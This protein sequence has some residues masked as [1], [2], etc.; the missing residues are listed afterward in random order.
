M[1]T[2]PRLVVA[3]AASGQG[4]TTVSVGLMGALRAYGHAVAPAKCGP[5]Y[6]DP[7]YHELA[8]GRPSRNLDPW[9]TSPEL[10][11]PLF[12]RG[13]L[14]PTP[15]DVAVIEGVMGLFDGR[16]G[17]D[18]FASTAHVAALTDSPVLLVV[19]ISSAARTVGALVRG[20]ATHD[21]AVRVAG[22]VLNKAGSDRHAAEVR[23]AV[24]QQ[25][26]PVLGV[27]PRDAGI[28]A[29]SRH[30]GLVPAS[31]RHDAQ[32]SLD[33]L[34]EQ[35]AQ[36]IDIDAVFEIA[37][38]APQLD[39]EPWAPPVVD[40][41]ARRVAVAGGRAFTFHYAETAEMLAAAGCE[42]VRFDPAT[43]RELPSGTTGLYLGGGFPE[44]HLGALATNTP[45][46]TQVRDAVS[47]GLP[48]VAECAGLL[49]LC[50]SL[51]G[52]PM[53]GV[54]PARAAMQPRLTLGYRDATLTVDS[55]LGPAGTTARGHEFHR[56]RTDPGHGTAAAW[57][58]PSG[59]EGFALDPART[60]RA[61]VHA[62]YLH[63][64]WA[65]APQLAAAFADAVHEFAPVANARPMRDTC[66][67]NPRAVDLRPSTD[68]RVQPVDSNAH[69]GDAHHGDDDIR[70][71]PDL[72][73]LA[74]N[75]RLPAPPAWLARELA[76]GIAGLG[77]Y[78]DATAARDAIARRHGV[79]PSMVLPTAGGAEAFTL[80]ARAIEG[81]TPLIVE[82]QFTE[83]A[84]ALA[85]AGR[86]A[87]R[88][89]LRAEH[90][91][92]LEP[93]AVDPAADLVFVGNPTNPTGVL[94]PRA[95]L[96]A[97]RRRGRV[98]VIDEAFADAVPG[99]TESCISPD[100]E[101]L[102]SM[103]VVRSLTKTW[104]VAGLRAGYV[105]GD[106]QLVELMRRQQPHWSVSSPALT[107]MLATTSDRALRESAQATRDLASAREHLVGALER[108]GL[109]PVPGVAPFV[110]VEVGDGV[111]EALR[112]SGFAVRRC[113]TFA[114]LSDRWIRIAVRDPHTIDTFLRALDEALA[115]TRSA[116]AAQPE[117]VPA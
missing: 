16:L 72:V 32:A 76:D 21:P 49:Y 66:L 98:L 7:G 114:G 70:D 109:R 79:D 59:P 12:L 71:R 62:S 113:D 8:T 73:D 46:L 20:L 38:T 26:Y 99:E 92:V 56:T 35:T 116:A 81:R 51:D 108:R 90:G 96:H 30:L 42:P 5:D 68:A 34:A 4:K 88:L 67:V 117:E 54:L 85:A 93:A 104:G 100:P 53:V 41:P 39:A 107:V 80:I 11:A 83:P 75:V 111:R 25:G 31:E 64:H 24:E 105:I 91:F 106:P 28:S 6:I 19:D 110:L 58:F 63:T 101:Q 60:G 95:T 10:V 61:T 78:P 40:R 2:Q 97:L 43:D 27:L 82:P 55:L 37:C 74:V 36:H 9:L 3:A 69:P 23:R 84:Q 103:L 33:R 57:H 94:H 102:Q 44:A 17:A 48:T 47:S 13:C 29:P 15:A 50:E 112:H 1:V 89:V 52:R 45:L 22:V 86:T 14:H 115:I 18:G 77:A 65:G 87:D